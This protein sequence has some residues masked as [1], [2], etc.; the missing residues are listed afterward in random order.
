MSTCTGCWMTACLRCTIRSIR[1]NHGSRPPTNRTF[2]SSYLAGRTRPPS[3]PSP[4]S[5]TAPFRDTPQF[6]AGS[7][8]SEKSPPGISVRRCT[9]TSMSYQ[10][11]DWVVMLIRSL[12]E[13]S[14]EEADLTMFLS[15]RRRDHR[16]LPDLCRTDDSPGSATPL[17]LLGVL[18][19]DQRR[20][21]KVRL[22][23]SFPERL[24]TVANILA[25]KVRFARFEPTI[26]ATSEESSHA[27]GHIT[28]PKN[29]QNSRQLSCRSC[30]G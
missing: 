30:C 3:P 1:M 9:R 7:N 5:P 13:R 28:G 23:S 15:D 8:I 6:A 10:P 22:K 21:D 25:L 17:P 20:D 2:R 27:V 18:L 14:V 11:P 4:T 16:R 24:F 26:P 19:P 12:T 29:T